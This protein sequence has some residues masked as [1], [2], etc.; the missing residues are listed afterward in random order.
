MFRFK[1]FG[2]CLLFATDRFWCLSHSAN[3][4]ARRQFVKR[5]SK[6]SKKHMSEIT[7]VQE[8][9]ETDLHLIFAS[10]VFMII[11]LKHYNLLS[12]LYAAIAV[13]SLAAS[14]FECINRG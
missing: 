3:Y 14:I 8:H 5:F 7:V 2:L 1:F 10:I 9:V 13:F 12:F 6:F 4:K 11:Y